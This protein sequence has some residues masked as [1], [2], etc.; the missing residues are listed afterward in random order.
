MIQY[1]LFVMYICKTCR[2]FKRQTSVCSRQQMTQWNA[3]RA[4][5]LGRPSSLSPEFF[6]GANQMAWQI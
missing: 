5:P 6:A 2:I 1:N 4:Q 3:S